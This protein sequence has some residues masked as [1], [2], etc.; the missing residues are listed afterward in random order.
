MSTNVTARPVIQPP[1]P[2]SGLPALLARLLPARTPRPPAGAA[3]TTTTTTWAASCG[4]ALHLRPVRPQ[5][6]VLL[7]GL[8]THGLGA[9]SRRQRFHAA[10]RGP[11]ALQLAWLAAADFSSHGAWVVTAQVQGLEQLVAEGCWVRCGT[12]G[13]AEFALSVADAW[14]RQGIGQR[15]LQA[16]VD[17]AR[18]QG[19]H[20]L[21]GDVL[22]GNLAMQALACSQGFG[23][24]AH[25]GDSTL[26]RADLPLARQPQGWLP[27]AW[28][29]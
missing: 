4:T 27:A 16:L 5:D 14:Q 12:A 28:F 10:V 7:A 20:S 26:L 15:L 18:A 8:F 2:L 23:C 1:A 3:T 11:S 6:A 19:L 9:A 24:D 29:H 17:S 13:G 21:V 22:P 25:P